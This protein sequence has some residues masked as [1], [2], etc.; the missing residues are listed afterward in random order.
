MDDFLNPKS[1]LTPGATGALMMLI[2]NTVCGFFPELAFRYVALGLSF[3]IGGFVIASVTANAL[4]RGGYWFLNSLVIFCVGVGTTNIAANAEKHARNDA[5]MLMWATRV[6]YA[7]VPSAAAQTTPAPQPIA[8]GA[9]KF[10]AA[11]MS[12][13]VIVPM[14]MIVVPM[15]DPPTDLTKIRL[16]NQKLRE[17]LELVQKTSAIVKASNDEFN[18][19]KADAIAKE[20]FFKR[21]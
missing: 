6:A 14:P 9:K 3:L 13:A 21:W 15:S 1:M 19:K 5:A 16:E 4:A 7:V 11:D 20:G 2:A 18:I 10:N 8:A 17:Q 12:K